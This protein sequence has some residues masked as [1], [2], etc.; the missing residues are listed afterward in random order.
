VDQPR[1]KIMIKFPPHALPLKFCSLSL[2]L[3][4]Y[5]RMYIGERGRESEERRL[6]VE[7]KT[8]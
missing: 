7:K 4:K 1:D 8:I 5:E 6:L 2:S 3:F